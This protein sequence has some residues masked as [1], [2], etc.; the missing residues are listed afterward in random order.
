[1]LNL[2]SYYLFPVKTTITI[3]F[4]M[5][6]CG[7]PT[8]YGCTN[9]HRTRKANVKILQRNITMQVYAWK[10][11]RN[12]KKWVISGKYWPYFHLGSKNAKRFFRIFYFPWE[13]MWL[14][15]W[16]S[17]SNAISLI[18]GGYFLSPALFYLGIILHC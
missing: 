6:L 18:A 1:M 8:T 7:V 9:V 4:F 12:C 17:L 10:I 3:V 14:N 16:K 15:Y 11:R 13:S 2:K 5:F